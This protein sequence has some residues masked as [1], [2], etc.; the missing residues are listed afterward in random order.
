MPV[1]P[2]T[3]CCGISACLYIHIAGAYCGPL[4]FARC[5]IIGH[6][7]LPEVAR[8]KIIGHCSIWILWPAY[9]GRVLPNGWTELIALLAAFLISALTTPA[10]ISGAVLLLPFQVSALGTPGPSVT[11]TNRARPVRAPCCRLSRAVTRTYSYR[12]TPASP[13]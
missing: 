6:R 13:A 9:C 5:N 12:L 1:I 11:P 7:L 2:R 4:I 3:R 10:G 8:R